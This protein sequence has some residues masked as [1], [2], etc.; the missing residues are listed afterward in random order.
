PWIA[1]I[2]CPFGQPRRLV[3]GIGWPRDWAACTAYVGRMDRQT[4]RDALD[5][6]R[7]PRP[8]GDKEHRR[9]IDRFAGGI[10]PQKLYGVPVGLMYFE[11][12]PRLLRSGVRLPAHGVP[13]DPDR[14][15][16]EAYPGVLA[17]GLIGRRSYKNDTVAKQTPDQHAA[18]RAIL[19]GLTTRAF[20]AQYGFTVEAPESLADDSG[21]DPLDALLCAVQAGWAW[22]QRD[23]GFGIPADADPLE[24]WISD[25]HVEAARLADG[26]GIR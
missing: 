16:I 25:P 22:G 15:V 14:T 5:A 3:E 7:T 8:V 26:G 1:G 13:G 21:A 4:F 23:A 19:D 11:A 6:Y 10:S 24:G 9:R 18:R 17:R 2:D 12:A 20:A